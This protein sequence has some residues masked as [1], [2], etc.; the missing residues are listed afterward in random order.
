[1]R[2]DYIRDHGLDAMRI[3]GA[4]VGADR[5]RRIDVFNPFTRDKLGSVPKAT[6]EE[7]RDAFA[8]AKA[9]NATLTRFE[10][11]DILNKAAAIVRARTDE[12]SALITAESGLARK[13]TTYECGRTADVLAFGAIEVLRDDAQVFSCDVTP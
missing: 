10:R 5:D 11:A 12:I 1:M 7:V 13:D 3:S 9:F 2:S 8:K 6:V 4:H